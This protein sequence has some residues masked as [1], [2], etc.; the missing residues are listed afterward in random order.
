[1]LFKVISA[2]V[3]VATSGLLGGLSVA[4]AQGAGDFNGPAERPPASFTGQQFVD[5]RGCV[6]LRAGYG[7]QVNWVPRVSRDRKPLCGYPATFGAKGAAAVAAAPEAPAAT[8]VPAKPAAS[9]V[10]VAAPPK[11]VAPKPAA[12][13]TATAKT[14]QIPPET[15]VA[16]RPVN[17][18]PLPATTAGPVL[19]A[20]ATP[21]SVIGARRI[22]CYT[23]APVAQVVQLANGG[24]AVVC[25]RGDGTLEGWRPPLYPRGA[26]PGVALGAPGRDGSYAGGTALAAAPSAVQPPP[27]YVAAWKDDRL[28]PL[29]GQGTPAGQAAQDE[30]WTREV[31]A[32]LVAEAGAPRRK[33]T[34]APQATFSTK[35]EPRA[36]AGLAAQPQPRVAAKAAAGAIYVQVGTF[37][38]P[39]NAEGASARLSALGLPVGKGNLTRGGKALRV[40]YAGPF[41]S[42]AEAQAGLGLARRAGFADAFIR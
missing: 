13:K 27:G 29:R 38:V 23:S 39:A 28:N 31:P 18:Q 3:L 24:R 5:S 32:R 15:Y 30:I 4:H 22:A 14:G 16:P 1:M 42:L 34:A 12:P 8:P 37:G 11:V 7:A 41:A 20:D 10:A 9:A 6:F 21:G 40:V 36:V 26:A 25:T 33:V 2:A 17:L 19:V 35:S